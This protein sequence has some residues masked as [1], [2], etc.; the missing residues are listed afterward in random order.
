MN[1][2]KPKRIGRKPV[3]DPWL[4]DAPMDLDWR[5]YFRSFCELHGEPLEHRG[6]LIFPDGWSY[7]ATDYR[8]PEWPPPEGE[9]LGRLLRSYWELRRAEVRRQ[10][11]L[12]QAQLESAEAQQRVRSAPL[13]RKVKVRGEDGK[14]G[15]TSG[16]LDLEAARMRIDF[17]AGDLARCDEQLAALGAGEGCP[18]VVDLT[19]FK[20]VG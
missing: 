10:L 7:S 9:S 6:R 18:D 1:R 19:N 2:A 4:P 14:L 3:K 12:S 11:Q 13:Q 20:V 5:A 8:G 16:T 15:W 17:L